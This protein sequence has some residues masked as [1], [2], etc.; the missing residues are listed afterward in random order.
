MRMRILIVEDDQHSRKGLQDCLM[1]DGHGVEAV[2]DG[3]QAFRKIK[4]GAFDLAIVDLD[5]PPIL[6]VIVSGW[7]VVRI[8]RAYFTEIPIII[9]SAQE[10]KA[11]HRQVERL[12]VSTFM[13]KPI[14]PARVKSVVRSLGPVGQRTPAVECTTG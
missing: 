12:K 9:L 8:L 13:V 14:D 10:D 5:L 6:G 2:P 4:E 1:A 11:I 3:W 7:D